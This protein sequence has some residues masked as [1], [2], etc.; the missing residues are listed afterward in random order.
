MTTD[1]DESKINFPPQRDWGLK[2][3]G[4]TQIG[5]FFP[6]C[7]TVPPTV[8]LD[9]LYGFI[10]GSRVQTTVRLSTPRL[11]PARACVFVSTHRR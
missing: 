4:D 3:S 9:R 10:L 11:Q 1:R 2:P 8:E 5:F 7:V 6:R